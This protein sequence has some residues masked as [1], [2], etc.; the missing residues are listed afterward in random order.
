MP[1]NGGL[2][3]CCRLRRGSHCHFLLSTLW[4]L[5]VGRTPMAAYVTFAVWGGIATLVVSGSILGGIVASVINEG[6]HHKEKMVTSPP[7]PAPPAARMRAMSEHEELYGKG[8]NSFSL[9]KD[10]RKLFT[11]LAQRSR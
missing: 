2:F 7:P 9:N 11:T 5:L 8:V 10:E 1:T 6:D 3:S 4:V